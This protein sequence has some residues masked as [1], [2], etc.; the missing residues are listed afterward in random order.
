MLDDLSILAS[1]ASPFNPARQRIERIT[2]CARV[3]PA[4]SDRLNA[5][6]EPRNNPTA[7]L[8]KQPDLGAQRRARIEVELA[9]NEDV[10]VGLKPRSGQPGPPGAFNLSPSSRRGIPNQP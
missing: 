10:A 3:N 7:P 8:A 9:G 4:Q 6:K 1:R 2:K 5:G